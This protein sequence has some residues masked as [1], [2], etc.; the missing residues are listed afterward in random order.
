MSKQTSVDPP[1]T[2][3]P[4]YGFLCP[5]TN[6]F[7]AFESHEEY[8]QFLEWSQTQLPTDEKACEGDSKGHDYEPMDEE[9]LQVQS[10]LA[11]ASILEIVEE[12]AASDKKVTE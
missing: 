5:Q 6:V 12:I 3:E 4:V 11:T 9:E 8:L 1:S 7:Y 10:D 2:S